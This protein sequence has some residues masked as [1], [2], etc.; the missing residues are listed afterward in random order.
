[1]P[2]GLFQ[3]RKGTASWDIRFSE[4]ELTI[5]F[6][7]LNF[8]IKNNA[9]SFIFFVPIDYVAL[10]RDVA[11]KFGYGNFDT[12]TWIKPNLASYGFNRLIPAT[13]FAVVGYKAISRAQYFKP[14]MPPHCLERQNYFIF[15]PVRKFTIN[16][17]G[18]ITN[19]HEKPAGLL[20]K[21]FRMFT[22][23]G[24]TILSL[25][26]GSGTDIIAGIASGCNVISIEKDET[27]Y[28][29]SV[30]RVNDFCSDTKTNTLGLELQISMAEKVR[31]DMMTK[32]HVISPN[33]FKDLGKLT[34]DQIKNLDIVPSDE[35]Q[36]NQQTSNDLCRIC[37]KEIDSKLVV[38]CAVCDAP[39]HLQ[40]NLMCGFN[41][42]DTCMKQK[43]FLCTQQHHLLRCPLLVQPEKTPA[44]NSR[45]FFILITFSY[46][47][48]SF[49]TI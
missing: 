38:L 24:G 20:V 10:L 6:T 35:K 12:L 7:G 22:Q 42:C 39:F 11:S 1:M 3:A 49:L 36:E 40:E 37:V 31:S 19:P 23:P 32:I 9:H 18:S 8:K 26:S 33:A 4:E 44:T 13:E 29:T 30:V 45:Y 46:L 17:D 34:E 47:H 2:Y 15:P 27:Q 21:W 43:I 14:A 28:T 5:L 25:G 41:E 48:F 16:T